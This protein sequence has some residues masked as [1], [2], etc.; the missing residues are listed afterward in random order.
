MGRMMS[1]DWSAKAEPVPY[2]SLDDP[3]SLNL[4][5]YV[6]NNPLRR[7]DFDGHCWKGFSFVCDTAQRFKNSLNYG[8][9]TDKQVDARVKQGQDNLRNHGVS[10]EGLSRVAIAGAAGRFGRTWQTYI[11]RHPNLQPYSGRTSGTGTPEQNLLRR[12][13]NH[14]MNEKGF[15]EAELDK[16]SSNPDAIRGREQ[17]LIDA[18]GKAQSE[19]GTSSNAIRGVAK[20]NPNAAVYQQAAEEEFGIID[21]IEILNDI[22]EI[23]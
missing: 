2:A 22:D 14:Q 8:F 6:G 5:A 13:A 12:D 1:P 19:S 11:K 7:I 4:Y 17:Q 20:D 15:G 16:S 9:I 23:P 10:A 18:N 21:E 3:Q